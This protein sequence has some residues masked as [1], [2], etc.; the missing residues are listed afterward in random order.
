MRHLWPVRDQLE[1]KTREHLRIA[2]LSDSERLRALT[3]LFERVK[4][5]TA[6]IE[7][8]D[9][10]PL[11]IDQLSDDQVLA[12]WGRQPGEETILLDVIRKVW[13]AIRQRQ[14]S[15]ESS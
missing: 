8:L 12:L 9:M 14:V 2:L 10:G 15:S 13:S 3:D 4:R 11:D 7:G 5:R 6:A 1:F